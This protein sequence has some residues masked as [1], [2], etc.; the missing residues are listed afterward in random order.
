MSI[1]R[2][3]NFMRRVYLKENDIK[4]LA[5][6]KRYLLPQFLYAPLRGKYTSLGDNPAFPP[7][8]GTPFDYSIIKNRFKEVS[9]VIE[10]NYPELLEMDTDGVATH[11]GKL[12][13]KCV[14]IEK[15]IRPQLERVCYNALTRIFSIP[16]EAVNIVCKLVDSIKYTDPLRVTP[17]SDT[18]DDAYTFEDIKD[19]Q[20]SEKA[21]AKRRLINALIQGASYSLAKDEAFYADEIEE[22]S[23]R[24]LPLY[25]E[26]IAI[27]DFLLFTKQEKMTDKDPKQGSYVTVNLGVPNEKSLIEAQGICF[28]LLLNEAVRGLFE[29]FAMH[30]LPQDKEKAMHIIRRA[31]FILAEPWDLRFGVGLWKKVEKHIMDINLIPYVFTNICKLKTSRF[32]KVMQEVF[33]GTRKGDVC[34]ENIVNTALEDIDYND[35]EERLKQKNIDKAIIADNY[36]SAAELNPYDADGKDGDEEILQELN[37]NGELDD[38]DYFGLLNDCSPADIDFEEGEE[39]LPGLEHLYV[40]VNGI[41]LPDEV[42][43]LDVQATR[44]GKLQ[45]KIFIGDKFQRLGFGTKLY[46]SFIRNFGELYSGKGRIMNPDAIGRIYQKLAMEPDIDVSEDDISFSARLKGE[47]EW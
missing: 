42:V 3:F 19:M 29:L 21:V 18:E 2:I 26:I 33:A 37:E 22:L 12:I 17:E 31:D 28:P 1:L 13:K 34:M 45:L 30:G 10:D 20:S 6:D 23:E 36:F 43:N 47:E 40:T 8:G 7:D 35:F 15:P 32:N 9:Q 27:N 5:G 4:E 24:L 44:N 39:I 14:E 46:K 41:V 38:V 16:E 11:L 25:E